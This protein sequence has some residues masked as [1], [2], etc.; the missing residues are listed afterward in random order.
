MTAVFLSIKVKLNKQ[1]KETVSFSA[2]VAKS[3]KNVDYSTKNLIIL[4]NSCNI[5]N[6]AKSLTKVLA[7]ENVALT[8]LSVTSIATFFA[9]VAESKALPGL[10][11][12]AVA[13]LV[14]LLIPMT[15]GGVK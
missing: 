14:R 11:I 9:A 6:I 10:A 12:V 1:M 5:C 3:T 7:S 4:A 13:A 8:V 2:H 15:K